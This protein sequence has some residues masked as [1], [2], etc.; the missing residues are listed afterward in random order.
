MFKLCSPTLREGSICNGHSTRD[1]IQAESRENVLQRRDR[2]ETVGS[3]CTHKGSCLPSV[4]ALH[5]LSRLH[6]QPVDTLWNTSH[7]I[8]DSWSYHMTQGV[9][10]AHMIWSTTKSYDS[11]SRTHMMWSIAKSN[12]SGGILCNLSH[13]H[14]TQGVG[15]ILYDLSQNHMTQGVRPP[16][17]CDLL[18]NYTTQAV[19]SILYDLLKNHMT[20]KGV[21]LTWTRYMST[22]SRFVKLALAST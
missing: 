17:W 5:N 1:Q 2:D 14:T 10:P 7:N 3:T 15:P 12:D 22:I 11:G 6:G 9:W 21:G 16:I 20:Q 18:Q 4:V 19:G 13:N 8:S